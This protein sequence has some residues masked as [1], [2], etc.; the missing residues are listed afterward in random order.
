MAKNKKKYGFF[1]GL[2]SIKN[3]FTLLT[4]LMKSENDSN[5]EVQIK[6]TFNEAL[7]RLNVTEDEKEEFLKNK[8]N[9]IKKTILLNYM[10]SILIVIFFFYNLFTNNNDSL[11]AIGISCLL[12][13][14][15]LLQ[16]LSGAFR[17]YQIEREELVKLKS[18]IIQPLK[19]FPKTRK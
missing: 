7:L 11:F 4:D 16:G 18:F 3:S 17:C 9:E 19:W 1:F 5:N 2:D 12:S 10:F 14:F 6:E 13:S 15:F 8:Y